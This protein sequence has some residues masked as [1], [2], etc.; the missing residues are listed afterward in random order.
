M[1]DSTSPATIGRIDLSGT[2]QEYPLAEPGSQPVGITVG[3]DGAMWFTEFA[4]NRIGRIDVT[5]GVITEF[6]LPEAGI[7]PEYV[8]A[9]PDGNLWFTSFD[10]AF[11]GRMTPAGAVTLL[12][13]NAPNFDIVVGADGNLWYSGF[14]PGDDR[15]SVAVEARAD[16][17]GRGIEHHHRRGRGTRRQRVV[18]LERRCHRLLPPSGPLVLHVGVG[19]A[20]CCTGRRH[21]HDGRR[22]Q[23]RPG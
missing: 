20:H 5:T 2:V 3:P 15:A 23:H 12:N 9:G 1:G 7:Q 4:G 22:R 11:I 6:A 16:D 18:H 8:A 14:S 10:G 13:A 21:H 17:T 19:D